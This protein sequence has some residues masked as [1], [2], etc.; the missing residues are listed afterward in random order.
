MT[1]CKHPRPPALNLLNAWLKEHRV[2]VP[3]FAK[4]VRRDPQLVHAWRHCR[5]RPTL[6]DILAIEYITGIPPIKWLDRQQQ[7]RL[8]KTKKRLEEVHG[9]APATA[10]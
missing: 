1:N 9:R 7:D 3:A 8:L 6:E 10:Q 4:L 5:S 2:T